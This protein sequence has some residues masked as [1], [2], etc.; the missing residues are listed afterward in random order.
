MIDMKFFIDNWE[1]VVAIAGLAGSPL[2]FVFGRK[3]AVAST[4]ITQTDAIK[5]LQ[6]AYDEWTSDGNERYALLKGEFEEFRH[7]MGLL[8]KEN[9]QQREE[10]RQLRA[11]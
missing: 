6:S 8:R 3:Q 9:Y 1:M 5:N 7:E 2:A 11:A 4:R 10:I